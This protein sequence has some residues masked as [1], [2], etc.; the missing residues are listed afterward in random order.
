[1]IGRMCKEAERR[2]LFEQEGLDEAQVKAKMTAIAEEV[3]LEM[4]ESGELSSS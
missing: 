4:L 1:M 3:Y 2:G